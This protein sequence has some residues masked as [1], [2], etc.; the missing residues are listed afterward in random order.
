MG[1]S[2]LGSHGGD[3]S[4]EWIKN[5]VIPTIHQCAVHKN[6]K[7]R[8]LSLKMIE[9]ILLDGS[10][11]MKH[12]SLPSP[13]DDSAGK[14]LVSIALSLTQDRIANVRLNVGRVLH[15]ALQVF[16]NEELSFIKEVLSEQLNSEHERGGDRDVIFFAKRCAERAETLLDERQQD[17]ST[18]LL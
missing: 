7:Q 13:S 3:A 12:R 17:V 14:E 8:L 6:S 9:S 1:G 4:A 16:E 11:Q 10:F 2:S 5:I 18:S 15:D